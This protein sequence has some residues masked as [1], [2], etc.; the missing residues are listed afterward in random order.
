MI[1]NL[2]MFLS[3]CLGIFCLYI[4]VDSIGEAFHRALAKD[5]SAKEAFLIIMSLGWLISTSIIAS[6]KYLFW[7][8]KGGI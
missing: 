7:L 2:I 6:M 8:V 3:L 1:F 4:V 5:D